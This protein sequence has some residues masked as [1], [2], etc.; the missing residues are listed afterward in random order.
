MTRAV[1]RAPGL[2]GR[3]SRAQLPRY[4]FLGKFNFM[5]DEATA[6]G[7]LNLLS[8]QY[9]GEI[10]RSNVIHSEDCCPSKK[11]ARRLVRGTSMSVVLSLVETRK[12]LIDT[13]STALIKGAR[14]CLASVD[15]RVRDKGRT[16]L[17]E[18]CQSDVNVGNPPSR[19]ADGK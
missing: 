9:P 6:R 11:V 4:P 12:Q 15:R 2:S 13:A 5:T 7:S 16:L 18:S 1:P 8:G 10:G 14:G 17:N 3:A 19:L